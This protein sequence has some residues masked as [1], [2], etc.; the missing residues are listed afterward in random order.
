[1]TAI[2]PLTELEGYR[3]DLQGFLVRRSV[4]S[5]TEVAELNRAVDA[6]A[7]RPGASIQSQRFAGLLEAGG[8]L[9]TL[10]DHPGIFDVVRELCGDQVRLD[11][12]YGIVM[13]PG[14]SG[15]ALHGGAQPF[16][17]AQFY[18]VE[19]GRIHTGL[20]A[21]QWALVDHQPGDGGFACIPGSHRAAFA[22]PE[23][24][25]LDHELVV[26]VTMEAGDLVV[27]SEALTHGTRPWGAARDRRSVLYK[28]SPGNS[29]WAKDPA[30]SERAM[31]KMTDRQKR[32]C[33]PASV[34]Y[35]ESP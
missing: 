20:I 22:R 4:L 11:H 10:M 23:S 34:A 33:Q 8:P 28:Y 5:A 2:G 19:A 18:V 32:L 29:S 12:A 13:A 9:L 26:E 30:C 25:D 16:D 35:H 15:L 3:F 31:R 1:M 14:T 27:F 21:V 24:V 17:P 6:L 7:A